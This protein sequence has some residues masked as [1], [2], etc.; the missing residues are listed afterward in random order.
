MIE[1]ARK[2]FNQQFS[3]KKYADFLTDLDRN[4]IIKL[5]FG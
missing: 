1:S 4:S 5:P 3:E 2:I